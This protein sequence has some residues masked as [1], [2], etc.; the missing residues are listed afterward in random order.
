MIAAGQHG[1]S[2]YIISQTADKGSL[3]YVLQ[4]EMLSNHL[5]VDLL[6][7]VA[8]QVLNA[9]VYLQH[10][11][12]QPHGDLTADHILLCSDGL[13]KLCGF[14]ARG[15]K[16]GP[17]LSDM[18]QL[19]KTLL[20]CAPK[21]GNNVNMLR[22]FA[23]DIA[24]KSPHQAL[25]HHEM[26]AYYSTYW[27]EDD[28]K[29]LELTQSLKSLGVHGYTEINEME[30][31]ARL[32]E[33]TPPHPRRN[34]VNNKMRSL[35]LQRQIRAINKVCHAMYYVSPEY[36]NITPV[37]RLS[38]HFDFEATNVDLSPLPQAITSHGQSEVGRLLCRDELSRCT[39]MQLLNLGLIPS[40]RAQP[41]PMIHVVRKTKLLPLSPEVIKDSFSTRCQTLLEIKHPNIVRYLDIVMDQPTKEVRFFMPHYNLRSLD[42]WLI[43]LKEKLSKKEAADFAM[44]VGSQL[45]LGLSYLHHVRSMAHGRLSPSQILLDKDGT[46]AMNDFN[47]VQAVVDVAELPSKNA[48]KHLILQDIRA[49]ARIMF[50]IV[51]ETTWE[52]TASLKS[53]QVT[54]IKVPHP[55]LRT[56][57][58]QMLNE[59]IDPKVTTYNFLVDPCF[60]ATSSSNTSTVFSIP[61]KIAPELKLLLPERWDDLSQQMQSELQSFRNAEQDTLLTLR[62]INI[63][64]QFFERHKM[65]QSGAVDVVLT[66][67]KH[68]EYP[69]SEDHDQKTTMSFKF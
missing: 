67:I 56:I 18:A 20:E 44:A 30:S 69:L 25:Q 42:V 26:R 38:D 40:L 15:K 17:I 36:K 35:I 59:S 52:M 37:F 68:L 1:D 43:K 54:E 60:T 63:R 29:I 21:E 49:V 24:N 53:H 2:A 65:M 7:S 28:E 23:K 9:L 11:L 32:D 22:S 12:K 27:E 10:K 64:N 51:S 66:V 45:L 8:C 61:T 31:W 50:C 5:V 62:K 41:E 34:E 58:S 19:S 39:Q 48:L 55:E 57:I 6:M 33:I 13:V 3:S 14:N 46:V 4:S 16:T 47:L